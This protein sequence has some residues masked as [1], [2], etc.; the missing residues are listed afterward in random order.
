MTKE[1][2]KQ[3]TNLLRTPITLILLI[4][5]VFKLGGEPKFEDKPQ[6][7]D[8]NIEEVQVIKLTPVNVYKKI[9]EYEIEHPKIVFSQV[10]VETGN[11]KSKGAKIK[12]NLFGFFNKSGHMSFDSWEESIIYYKE[13]QNKKYIGGNY[14][15][16][17]KKVGYAE[18]SLYI[19]KLMRMEYILFNKLK[20]GMD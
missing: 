6:I 20:Y 18:D 13:W 1:N 2:F 17:L 7:I 5:F 19:S 9:I 3:K 4:L 15:N 14:Y 8:T 12:N 11:L 16:F 10:M